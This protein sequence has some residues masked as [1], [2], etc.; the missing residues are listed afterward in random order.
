MIEDVIRLG[1]GLERV[2]EP[3]LVDRFGE[4]RKID[5]AVAVGPHLRRDDVVADGHAQAFE[6]D[7]S[8]HGVVAAHDRFDRLG[9]SPDYVFEALEKGVQK[10]PDR[11]R[12]LGG[13]FGIDDDGVAVEL[14]PVVRHR[15][16][17]DV[18]HRH[19][20]IFDINIETERVAERGIDLP[21]CQH[22]R[23]HWDADR[24]DRHLRYIDIIELGEE[25]PFAEGDAAAPSRD[26]R[27]RRLVVD[28]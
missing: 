17:Y 21:G 9:G 5:G 12:L 13:E 19:A 4:P 18:V 8:F 3:D 26:Y 2:N 15:H 23:T 25:R 22:R 24:F 16:Q 10:R 27:E 28:H 7:L 6:L 11:L 14:E 1:L 20:A